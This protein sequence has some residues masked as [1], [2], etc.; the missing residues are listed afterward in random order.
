MTPHI[1]AKSSTYVN[2][3]KSYYWHIKQA[4]KDNY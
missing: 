3:N 4:K 2:D 1:Y